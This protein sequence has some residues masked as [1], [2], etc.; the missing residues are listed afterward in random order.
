MTELNAILP[1]DKPVGPT[2][3]DIVARA[4][5]ALRLRRI[6]H[7]G[8]LDPF[9]SGLLLLCLGPATRLAEYLTSL[10]KTYQAVLRLGASTDT[11]DCTG[12]VLAESDAWRGITLEALRAALASQVGEID[13]LPPRFSAKK[14]AGERMYAVARRGEEMERA[15]VRVTVHSIEL[16]AFDP[17]FAEFAVDCSSGTYIRA[18]ARDVGEALSVGA[19]LTS[20]RRTRVGRFAVE[21]AVAVDAFEDPG[22]VGGALFSPADAVSHLPSMDVD[23][24]AA[25]AVRNGR[26]VPVTVD[27]PSGRPVALLSKAGELIAIGERVGEWMRPNKVFA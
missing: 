19:H 1:V 3:H 22:A 4:R 7:T 12:E 15:P 6:G 25:A 27:L 14:V 8:T 10:P 2:S 21:H 18:I 13:Q 17:P 23:Q 5:R 16:R 11:D 24:D 20:L 26:A 9:A